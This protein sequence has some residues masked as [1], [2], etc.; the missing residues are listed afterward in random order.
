MNLSLLSS[1]VTDRTIFIPSMNSKDYISHQWLMN[2]S[3]LKS[4]STGNAACLFW[5]SGIWFWF[6]KLIPLAPFEIFWS[7]IF[8][9]YKMQN[10]VS[11]LLPFLNPFLGSE[12]L[13]WMKACHGVMENKE[14][15]LYHFNKTARLSGM[16]TVVPACFETLDFFS[17][18]FF[19]LL[20]TSNAS[21]IAPFWSFWRVSPHC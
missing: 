3:V 15:C 16:P 6:L 12:V 9:F 18:K 10:K 5:K 13:V 2:W 17:L 8:F 4:C 7:L 19:C 11:R 1:P 21:L 20:C 14:D